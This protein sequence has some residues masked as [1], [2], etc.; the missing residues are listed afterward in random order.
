MRSED[1]GDVHYGQQVSGGSNT[2]YDS[3]PRIV[4]TKILLA[5]IWPGWAMALAQRPFSLQDSAYDYFTI[6]VVDRQTGRGVPMV[7]LRTVNNISYFTDSNGTIAFY[8]AGLMDRDVFFYVE[9]HGYEFP[10]DGFGFR[11]IRLKTSQGAG[12]VIKID[13]INIAERLYRVTGQGIYRD[14][15]LAGHSVPLENP[16]LNG[17]VVGQDSVDTCIYHGRLFWFWGDT[18]RPSYPLGHFAMAGA[19][20]DLPGRGGLDPA[21]GVNLEYC[22]DEKGFS[23]PLC[24]LKERGLVWLD[25]FLTVKD[26]EGRERIIAKFARLKNLGDVY[27][28]GLVVFND[29]TQ[30]FEPLLRTGPDLLPYPNFGHAVGVNVDGQEYYYFATQFPLAVRMRVKAQWDCVID[31]NRYEVLT[32]LQAGRSAEERQQ[33][34]DLAGADRPYCWV[35]F[36]DL[37]GDEASAKASVSKALKAEKQ[38]VHLYDIE[39]GKQVAPHG[40]SVYFNTYRRRWVMI[41]VQQFGESSFLGEVWYAE[42]D[43]PVGP[44]AYARK[45]VTHNKYSFYNPKHHP[46]FDQD[47]GRVL[48][49]EGTYSQTFSGSAENPTPLYDYNQIMYRLNLDDRRLALPVSVYQVRDRQGPTDYL[50]RDGVEKAGKWDLIA[51][52]PFYAIEPAK[53]Y[54]GL[55]PVYARKILAGKGQTIS[56][57]LSRPHP[58]AEPLFYAWPPDDPT[59]ENPCIVLLYDY[60]HASTGRHLYSTKPALSEKGWIRTEN[61]LCR[62]W[63]APP[64]VLLLDGKAKP[65]AGH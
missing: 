36:G 15:V 24:R 17:Q 29:S 65:T 5:V 8:E 13:R 45:I 54:S 62:V 47:G 6:R 60:R 28:R 46:Y 39:S 27:E 31:P 56:L 59:D 61:P 57:S 4:L 33:R 25:G 11:G 22:V 9:S 49:F 32:S 41:F 10:K 34:L 14:S 2:M 16:V 48:F 44:W 38:N 40:G 58:T 18:S 51:S 63:K 7:E 53:T 37:T 35:G 20:S 26:K 30:S 3:Y 64:E 12:V 1:G 50:L 55:V 42:A 23:R 43:S 52:I 19:F 21:I